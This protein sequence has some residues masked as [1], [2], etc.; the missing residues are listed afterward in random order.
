MNGANQSGATFSA[1]L[2][3]AGGT[4][5]VTLGT[6]NGVRNLY[7]P[8]G[9]GAGGRLLNPVHTTQRPMTIAAVFKAAA[10]VTDVA[11]MTGTTMGR[12]AT[13]NYQRS[14]GGATPTSINHDG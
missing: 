14:S 9:T 3:N 7:S 8:G 13:G 1:T 4:P 5:A 6:E 2:S 11:A 10:G 12:A